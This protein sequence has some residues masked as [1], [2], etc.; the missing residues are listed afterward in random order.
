MSVLNQNLVRLIT[1]D[2][3]RTLYATPE[4]KKV[5]DF[6]N[7][8]NQSNYWANFIIREIKRLRSGKFSSDFVYIST[9]KSQGDES[10]RMNL[11]GCCVTVHP[12]SYYG[13]MDN[14]YVVSDIKID[15]SYE[16]E[17]L[18]RTKPQLLEARKSDLNKWKLSER[19]DGKLNQN[20]KSNDWVMVGINGTG[21]SAEMA[22]RVVADHLDNDRKI[23]EG[24]VEKVGYNLFYTPSCGFFRGFR[25]LKSTVKPESSSENRESALLLADVIRS[26]LL[27]TGHKQEMNVRWVTEKNGSAI[28]TQA[29]RIL[30]DQGVTLG[31]NHSLFL[32]SPT[33]SLNAAYKLSQALGMSVEGDF[34]NNNPDNFLEQIGAQRLGFG[35]LANALER[36]KREQSYDWVNVGQQLSKSAGGMKGVATNVAA[37]AGALALIGTG[38]GG[39]VAAFASASSAVQAVAAQ[40]GLIA[41]VAAA[42]KAIAPVAKV[43]GISINNSPLAKGFHKGT[44]DHLNNARKQK[45]A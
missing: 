29:M 1:S 2:Q 23:G 28:L 31:K 19:K 39:I 43:A 4:A 8:K 35:S 44:V 40:E 7:G 41:G 17:R 37:V 24:V 30:R 45:F 34:Y 21:D 12:M 15:D 33:S 42:G 18:E 14:S 11:P 26:S 10:F 16:K 20:L 27:P 22:A 25:L 6:L 36:R 32:S 38:P 3:G 5:F 13:T 9:A